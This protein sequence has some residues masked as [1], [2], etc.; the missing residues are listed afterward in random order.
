MRT[1]NERP[2]S[3]QSQRDR[4]GVFPTVAVF[5]VDIHNGPDTS[6][7]LGPIRSF[8]QAHVLDGVRVEGGEEGL[9]DGD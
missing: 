7:I 1:L 3:Q 8:I 4:T 6:A 9:E 2:G 5:V